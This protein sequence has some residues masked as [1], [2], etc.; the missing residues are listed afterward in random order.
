MKG[1][2]DLAGDSLLCF[3][4]AGALA[5][6]PRDLPRRPA[7]PHSLSND[8][9]AVKRTSYSVALRQKNSIEWLME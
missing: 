9:S 7:L 8:V 4:L 2:H 3:P 1:L 6:K 5:A